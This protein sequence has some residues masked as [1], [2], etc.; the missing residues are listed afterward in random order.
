MKRL[1]TI[2]LLT[3]STIFLAYSSLYAQPKYPTPLKKVFEKHGGMDLWQKQ[4]AFSYDIVRDKGN[5]THY[6][7]LKDR[8]DKIEAPNF[9]MG[10]DGQDVWVKEKGKK[11]EGNAIFYHN[12]MFYFY[13]MPF[14][15]GDDGIN[16]SE[17]KPI[18]FEGKTYPGVSI[19]YNAG[20]GS[21][22]E[23]EYFIHYDPD[24]YQMTWLG[25]TVTY[26]TKEKSDKVKWI[27]Y[28][29]WTTIDG[30]VLPQ[31]MTWYKF[32]DGKLTE[33][34]STAKFDKIKL[35]S[36]PYGDTFFA[37]PEGATVAK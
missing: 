3:L 6:I 15:L 13:A 23:D 12:L 25:Y 30:I 5:E 31:S 4:P 1:A 22:P 35:S 34:R 32:E 36:K 26:Y 24:T 20:V 27:R 8:R 11:Y 33:P 16:Y 19:S 37:K 9:D 14:V 17:T 28:D 7:N 18:T 21:S 10:F 2:A 29:D